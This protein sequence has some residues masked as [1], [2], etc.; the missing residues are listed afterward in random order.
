MLFID[1]CASN[2]SLELWEDQVGNP[3]L[4]QI[5]RREKYLKTNESAL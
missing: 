2:S 1:F 3:T 5:K 4:P